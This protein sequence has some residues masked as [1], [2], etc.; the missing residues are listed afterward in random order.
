MT[1]PNEDDGA[2]SAQRTSGA[3][4][5]GGFLVSGGAAF[6]V[7]AGVLAL[8]TR[9]LGFNPYGA[10]VVAIAAAMVV[11]WLLHRRLTFAVTMRPSVR[12][13]LHY[14]ALQ[15]ASVA[16]N[17][18]IYAGLIALL[19]RLD[20]LIALFLAS[21]VAMAVSYLGMRFGVFKSGTRRSDRAPS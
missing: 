6:A 13:F 20:P 16:T 18:A 14:A 15:W 8:L 1:V 17:Y 10:R 5:W 12:E 2:A 7:D 3:R 9:G 19:P 21:V 4:H 11:G